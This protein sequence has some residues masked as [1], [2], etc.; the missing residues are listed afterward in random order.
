MAAEL[1]R[2]KAFRDKRGN[3]FIYPS[4]IRWPQDDEADRPTECDLI[5]QSMSLALATG[6][7]ADEGW[8]EFDPAV[9]PHIKTE[10]LHPSF[11]HGGATVMM[12][13]GPAFDAAVRDQVA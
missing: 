2:T 7:Q 13:E 8:F 3:R 6:T 4:M 12:F 9:F 1:A 11:A 5:L 10:I